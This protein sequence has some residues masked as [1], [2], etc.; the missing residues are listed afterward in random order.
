MMSPPP[1]SPPPRIPPHQV[2]MSTPVSIHSR[3]RHTSHSVRL[4]P[5]HEEVC[6]DAQKQVNYIS[7]MKERHSKLRSPSYSP[8]S[9]SPPVQRGKRQPPPK[10]PRGSSLV[11]EDVFPPEEAQRV[12]RKVDSIV[13]MDVQKLYQN[14]RKMT[15]EREDRREGGREGGEGEASPS[16][17]QRRQ[18]LRRRKSWSSENTC[19]RRHVNSI[20]E[21]FERRGSLEGLIKGSPPGPFRNRLPA[22]P[23]RGNSAPILPPRPT[24]PP[25]PPR[26]WQSSSASKNPPVIPPH[27]PAPLLPPRPVGGKV[28]KASPPIVWSQ[29]CAP[30]PGSVH[31]FKREIVLRFIISWEISTPCPAPC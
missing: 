19:D 26:P 27:T 5:V 11:E 7:S 6:I 20:I 30:F 23:L 16:P 29:I 24:R 1:T 10:P 4:Y 17:L 12:I 15:L 13:D 8:T 28:S 2:P 31:S 14:Y 9:P 25:H 21:L 22:C 18:Q 3:R